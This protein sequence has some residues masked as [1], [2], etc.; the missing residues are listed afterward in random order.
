[1]RHNELQDAVN[2]GKKYTKFIGYE[3]PIN[4]KWLDQINRKSISNMCKKIPFSE[5]VR[6]TSW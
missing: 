1:M 3:I 4:F 6:S 5:K 2:M